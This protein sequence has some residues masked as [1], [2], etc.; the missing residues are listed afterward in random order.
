MRHKLS[1][2]T[3]AIAA[4]ALFSL[5]GCVETKFVY[6]PGAPAAGVTPIPT[7]IAVLPFVDGTEDFTQRG[8]IF[9]PDNLRFNVVKTGISG[10]MAAL[11]PDLWAKAFADEMVASGRFRD[12]K[13]IYSPS[14]L[15]DE[16]Y[17]VEGTLEK[18]YLAGGWNT[19]NEYAL[20]LRALQ[21]TDKT[22]VWA[23]EVK[24]VRNT[25]RNI[26]EGCGM[27]LQC[28]TDHFHADINGVIQLMY[29]EAI[30]DLAAKLSRGNES[31]GRE[32]AGQPLIP[33]AAKPSSQVAPG[34]VDD[35]IEKILME[36]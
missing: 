33:V 4:L 6:K 26:Y 19:P 2:L 5:T 31:G 23:K 29:A 30:A 28:M 13:F 7:K 25:P 12:V 15:T 32:D 1:R 8:S 11:T 17:F 9:D 10:S 21:R 3:L 34:S 18:A 16:T 36:K 24:S 35:T 22:A 20:S 27:G 14:E